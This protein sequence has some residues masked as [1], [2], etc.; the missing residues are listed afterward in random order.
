MAVFAAED[1]CILPAAGPTAPVTV[2]TAVFAVTTATANLLVVVGSA[3]LFLTYRL[4]GKS[5]VSADRADCSLGRFLLVAVSGDLAPA[6]SSS[7]SA[8]ESPPMGAPPDAP[9][10]ASSPAGGA[11]AGVVAAGDDGVGERGAY[12]VGEETNGAEL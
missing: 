12:D 7:D 8:S 4:K 3:F 9:S 2:S 6:A 5:N 1:V 11:A 10:A